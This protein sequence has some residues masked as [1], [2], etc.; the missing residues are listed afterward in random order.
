[1][2]TYPVPGFFSPLLLTATLGHSYQCYLTNKVKLQ[3]L[4][5][6]AQGYR[7]TDGKKR[8]R[9]ISWEILVEKPRNGI[10]HSIFISLMRINLMVQT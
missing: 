8:K 9:M 1:M 3:E 4:M 5:K 7:H 6:F 10:Y 2:K